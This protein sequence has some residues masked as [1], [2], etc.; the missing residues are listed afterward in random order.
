MNQTFQFQVP[1]SSA[2]KGIVM[3]GYGGPGQLMIQEL[4]VPEPW[5]GVLCC[6]PRLDVPSPLQGKQRHGITKCGK[7]QHVSN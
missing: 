5:R 2:M 1:E 3:Q 7:Y 4:A 6:S